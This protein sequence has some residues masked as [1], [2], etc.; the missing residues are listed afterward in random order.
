MEVEVVQHAS[1]PRFDAPQDLK[2]TDLLRKY[3]EASN[4]SSE[5]LEKA[6]SILQVF[7]GYILK[8]L[9]THAHI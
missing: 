4:M 5:A 3:A 9:T 2:P 1:T 6:L 7:A 8:F